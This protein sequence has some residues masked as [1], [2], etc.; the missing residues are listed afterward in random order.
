MSCEPRPTRQKGGNVVLENSRYRARL[1]FRLG[2]ISLQLPTFGTTLF[3]N[4]NKS[5]KSWS[6][7]KPRRVLVSKS[8][9]K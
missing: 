5:F 3:P 4:V 8:P 2:T 1:I 9:L 7:K 6:R